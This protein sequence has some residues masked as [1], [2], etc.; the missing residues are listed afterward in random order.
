MVIHVVANSANV[1]KLAKLLLLSVS[2]ALNNWKASIKILIWNK[3]IVKSGAVLS[4]VCKIFANSINS[5]I[6]TKFLWCRWEAMDWATDN[7]VIIK[8]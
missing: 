8:R 5:K 6:E 4:G 2:L 1:T 3:N 7:I